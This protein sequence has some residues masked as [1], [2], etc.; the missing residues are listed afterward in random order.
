MGFTTSRNKTTHRLL[1][2]RYSGLCFDQ[3]ANSGESVDVTMSVEINVVAKVLLQTVQKIHYLLAGQFTWI[4][5]CGWR[6]LE[7]K[8]GEV[9]KKLRNCVNGSFCSV[10]KAICVYGKTTE[11]TVLGP[12]K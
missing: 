5:R 6:I 11:L 9:Y 8:I 10:N 2:E 12:K 4:F 7:L 3:K 1:G